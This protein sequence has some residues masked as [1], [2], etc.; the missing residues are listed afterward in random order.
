MTYTCFDV[1]IDGGVAHVQLNRPEALN[2]M[3][4]ELWTELPQVMAELDRTGAVRAIVLSSTGRH[5]SA[6]MDLGVFAGNDAPAGDGGGRV[7][8]GRRRGQL[9]QTVKLLQASLTSLEAVRA[10]VLAAIQ[11][12]CVGGAVDLVTAAD[13]RYASADAFF[14]V[15][16]I[17]I[18][19]TADVGTLQRLP[20][21]I[22]EGVAREMAYLGRRLPARRAYELGLVN[23]VFDDHESLVAGVLEVAAEIA[24]KSPLAIWGTKEAIKYTRDHSVEDSLNFI[25]TWQTGMFQPADMLESFAA[26]GEKRDPV[27]DDLTPPPTGI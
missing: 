25:A 11:G 12:G 6:G 2:S 27:F 26:Q 5:F 14:V 7:E 9:W 3:T 19:M 15:Q 17:N 21:L 4:R 8:A 20:K 16:E 13:L 18:G 10:P 1:A 24:A 22:P 23:E